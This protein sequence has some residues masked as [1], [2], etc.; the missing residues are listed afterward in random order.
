M[1]TRRGPAPGGQR[2]D[3]F[4][5]SE[6]GPPRTVPCGPWTVTSRLVPLILP[7]VSTVKELPHPMI[8]PMII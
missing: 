4:D 6:F 2:W 8:K 7:L 3:M 5:F 1:P